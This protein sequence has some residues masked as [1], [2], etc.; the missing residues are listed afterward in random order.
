MQ[1]NFFHIA[2]L[3]RLRLTLATEVKELSF[4]YSFCILQISIW[5]IEFDFRIFLFDPEGDEF[6]KFNSSLQKLPDLDAG[7]EEIEI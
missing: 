4:I 5:T 3:S 1:K 6:Q 2:K 7:I